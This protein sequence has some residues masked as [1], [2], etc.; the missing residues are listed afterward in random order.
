MAQSLNVMAGDVILIAAD[1]DQP[2]TCHLCGG[3]TDFDE[4]D[5]V[6]QVHQCL[7]ANCGCTFTTELEQ[8]G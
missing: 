6:T 1:E 8:E 2:V 5:E 3:R 7:N 4:I